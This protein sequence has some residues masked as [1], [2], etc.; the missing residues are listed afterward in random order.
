MADGR[1]IIYRF[2]NEYHLDP[3]GLSL[4]AVT[5]TRERIRLRPLQAKREYISLEDVH[6]LT[7]WRN[8]NR[9]H[10]LTDFTATT[11][12]T[13]RWVAE[14]IGPDL[15]RIL[16]MLDA[17]DGTTFGHVG[18]Y[19]IQQEQ[20]YC[21]LDN[22]VRGRGGPKG[23]MRAAVETLCLWARETLRLK[24]IWVRV[25]ADNPAVSFYTQLGFRL[26]KDMPLLRQVEAGDFVRWVEM[27][28]SSGR[29][30]AD[31]S[32]QRILRYMELS[33]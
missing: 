7:Q 24:N 14:I 11:E 15:T 3:E 18:L 22:I 33:R 29:A 19:D 17:A 25:M 13:F 28:P 1:A 27:S 2:K 26:V 4:A 5:S 16:F 23:A 6:L 21:E 31:P 32:P 8:Q 12:R 9:Q 30:K 20:S 10:F